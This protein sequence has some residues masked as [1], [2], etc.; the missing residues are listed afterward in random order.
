MKDI[1]IIGGGI[2][3]LTA[4]L[5]SCRSGMK[6]LLLEKELCGGQIISVPKVENYPGTP[7]ISGYALSDTL[8]SQAKNS[9]CE[10]INEPANGISIEKDCF[11]VLTPKGKLFCKAIIIATGA[12]K[13]KL[14]LENEKKF[15][16]C[17]I[18]YC[19]SCDGAFYKNKKVCVCGGGNAALDDA[20]YLSAVC[21]EVT[22][23]HR[24]NEFRGNTV[25]LERLKRAPNVKF[26]LNSSVT[27]LL[28]DDFLSEIEITENG[29]N[30][31]FGQSF[32]RLKTDGL[33]VAIGQVPKNR[34]FL[35]FVKLDKLGYIETDPQCQTMTRG[36]FAAGDCKSNHL[37]QL[38]TAAADGAIAATS[39]AEHIRQ[40]D[41]ILPIT[42]LAT[43]PS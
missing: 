33:F 7:N 31:A 3:G 28:G 24:R 37:C 17:G 20:L 13:R 40:A 32:Y 5:Y 16:G 27:A 29:K 18:S 39:A 26:I 12:E 1:I 43:L 23:I 30:Y 6:V 15:I 21:K 19:A 25:T 36:I 41:F 8:V 42:S 22:I 38:V 11:S 35:P 4:A 2:A 14:D 10:I 9:G 34:L